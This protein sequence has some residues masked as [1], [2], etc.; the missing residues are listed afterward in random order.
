MAKIDET[1]QH[2][3]IGLDDPV[4]VT[5]AGGFI[6]ARVVNRLLDL[7][8]RRV[9]CFVR[10]SG[11]GTRLQ[12]VVARHATSPA[13]VEIVHGNL[14]SRDDCEKAVAGIAV[15]YHLAAGVDKSFAGCFM[16]SVLATR[17]LLDA[18]VAAKTL[19]RFVNTSS[20]SVYSNFLM[21]R[22]ELFTE[23]TPLETVPNRRH[24]AYGYGKLKQD[25]LVER[26]LGTRPNLN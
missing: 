12:E 8:F 3:I 23:A 16:N 26:F 18:A 13:S 19:K 15:I 10:P 11:D 14:L 22:G 9:R 20:F 4:L 17:N 6:G 5:G 2:W 24:D 7:G 1:S 21:K 25:K